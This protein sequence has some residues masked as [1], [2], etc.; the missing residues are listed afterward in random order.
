MEASVAIYIVAV[1]FPVVAAGLFVPGA[2]LGVRVV[3]LCVG[4][5]L[6]YFGYAVGRRGVRVSNDGL[7]LISLFRSSLIPW[8]RV[9]HAESGERIAIVLT[10][11]APVDVPGLG[12]SL[13]GSGFAQ[14]LSEA[15]VQ[16]VANLLNEAIVANGTTGA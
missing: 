14:M 12:G 9:S 16:K 5:V 13:G 10:D 8:A 6:A 4:L 2:P 1:V 7:T 3:A 15:R 11:G